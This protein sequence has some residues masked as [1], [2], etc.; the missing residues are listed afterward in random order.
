MDISY[1]LL[2]ITG[3]PFVV[4]AVYGCDPARVKVYGPGNL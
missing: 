3:S 1:D 4:D 2:P